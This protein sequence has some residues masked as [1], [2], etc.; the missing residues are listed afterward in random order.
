VKEI[1][2]MAFVCAATALAVDLA[3]WEDEPRKPLTMVQHE[4]RGNEEFQIT[5]TT[6]DGV[7]I[8]IRSIWTPPRRAEDDR[9]FVLGGGSTLSRVVTDVLNGLFFGYR[10]TVK[11]LPEGKVRVEVAALPPDF[12]PPVSLEAGCTRCPAFTPLSAALVRYPEP[13]VV[14]SGAGLTFELLRN[15]KTG[16][17]LSDFIRVRLEGRTQVAPANDRFR[18]DLTLRRDDG[19]PKGVAALFRITDLATGADTIHPLLIPPESNGQLRFGGQTPQNVS[20]E[21]RIEVKASASAGTVVYSIEVREGSEL[22][23][24]ER[25]TSQYPTR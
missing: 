17:T 18:V 4:G 20:W 11:P 14:D 24:A 3:A 23:H 2:G 22:V 9:G 5:A 1:L 19:P 13:Q 25:V 12:R 7:W 10:L 21:A 8:G 6:D 16:E 15:P